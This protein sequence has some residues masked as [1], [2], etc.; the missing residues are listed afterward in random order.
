MGWYVIVWNSDDTKDE[1]GPFK[2]QAAAEDFAVMVEE[3]TSGWTIGIE[4]TEVRQGLAIADP[5]D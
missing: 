3:Q 1:H 2:T 5:R 4:G